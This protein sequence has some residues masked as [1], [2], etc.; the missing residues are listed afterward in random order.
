[1]RSPGN[2]RFSDDCGLCA[3]ERG[4]RLRASAPLGSWKRTTLVAGLRLTG[5]TASMT[6]DS[7]I[8]GSR[9]LDYVR[10]VL[11]PT[12]TPGDI[13]IIDNLSSHRSDDVRNAI[14]A[15]GASVR[16]FPPYSRTST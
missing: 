5:T 12:L 1:M 13:V 8:N 7:S 15:V 16:L 9:F 10:R 4:E 11:A 3:P 14:E 2:V 6:I